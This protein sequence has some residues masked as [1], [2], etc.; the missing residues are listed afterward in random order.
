MR[1]S[2]N[3]LPL[4]A[5]FIA[6]QALIFI[7]GMAVMFFVMTV[8]HKKNALDILSAKLDSTAESIAAELR[9]NQ[10]PNVPISDEYGVFIVNMAGGEIVIDQRKNTPDEQEIWQG[11][12][13]KFIYE[14]QKQK[15]GWIL[16]P[17]ETGWGWTQKQKMIRY[18]PVDEMGWILAV[19]I[20]WPSKF[21]L[22]NSIIN[23][24]S[25]EII[26]L[27]ILLGFL[28]FWFLT[29]IYLSRIEKFR[30]H[31]LKNDLLSLN[32]EE[33]LWD[34]SQLQSVRQD[35]N[36]DKEIMGEVFEPLVNKAKVPEPKTD[37]E[38]KPKERSYDHAPESV[39][40]RPDEREA[41]LEK[42][43]VPFKP[44]Q[45]LKEE[46]KASAKEAGEK[47]NID[48]HQPVS[49]AAINVNEIKS[50]ALK[51]MIQQLRGR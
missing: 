49:D 48:H 10:A 28:A 40:Q 34:Q 3:P 4:K 5:L 22:L 39:T 47:S 35:S 24:S 30:L 23:T 36:L 9:S 44:E 7:T 20:S 17:E 37:D 16:Y 32:G 15:R 38:I 13:S 33:K 42:K 43:A 46:P 1:K 11:H 50:S 31:A 19:E 8:G 6:A 51:K 2:N 26:L 25:Y 12:R 45:P 14:M 21:E 41:V 18:V 29:N 27:V